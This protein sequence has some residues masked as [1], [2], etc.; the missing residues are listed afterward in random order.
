MEKWSSQRE[1]TQSI[2]QPSQSILLSNSS[3]INMWK[4]LKGDD[5][6]TGLHKKSTSEFYQA[7]TTRRS[8][9]LAAATTHSTN[10]WLSQMPS[11]TSNNRYYPGM[12]NNA[13]RTDYRAKQ[14]LSS[15]LREKNKIMKLQYSQTNF[16]K[17]CNSQRRV[18]NAYR[19]QRALAFLNLNQEAKFLFKNHDSL[20]II[21]DSR[22]I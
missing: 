4:V 15:N 21:D 5:K 2:H 18:E 8:P 1:S 19:E 6:N 17:F 11:G 12:T 22:N 20:S 16:R 14:N 13:K 10:L 7:K 3:Q 9:T